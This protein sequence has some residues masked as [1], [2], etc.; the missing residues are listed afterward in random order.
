VLVA[1]SFAHDTWHSLC[2]TAAP[3]G[4]T[5]RAAARFA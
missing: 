1:R 5:V 3:Y 2:A 4:Y